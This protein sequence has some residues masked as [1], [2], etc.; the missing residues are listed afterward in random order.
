M[1]GISDGYPLIRRPCHLRQNRTG[2]INHG[3]N[4][5]VTPILFGQN[6]CRCNYGPVPPLFFRAPFGAN[7]VFG[8]SFG[9]ALGSHTSF[10][11]R[12]GNR[13]SCRYICRHRYIYPCM[14][15]NMLLFWC[16]S[17]FSSVFLPTCQREREKSKTHQLGASHARRG[18][19][20]CIWD[21]AA[22]YVLCLLE[23]AT[24]S[25]RA[26][27]PRFLSPHREKY[28]PI[29][30]WV[31]SFIIPFV[32]CDF[33]PISWYREHL[34]CKQCANICLVITHVLWKRY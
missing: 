34:W 13:W 8:Y 25:T 28:Y 30:S 32:A 20:I 9:P 19:C 31:L 3:L 1:S 22:Y 16:F 27:F 33:I 26:Y 2:N 4:L 14:T 11:H 6:G 12:G 21:W 29:R 23:I 10:E 18:I 24:R 5:C 15:K 7:G 17:V